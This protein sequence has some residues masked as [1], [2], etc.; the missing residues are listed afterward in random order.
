MK[1]KIQLLIFFAFIM[2]LILVV[3]LIPCTN[4]IVSRGASEDGSTMITYAADSHVLYGELYHW[5]AKSYPPGSMLDVYEWDT[6]KF[7]GQIKQVEQTYNV[8]GN[9]NEHQV[10]I[11]ETT[12]GGRR[13]LRNKKGI[14]DYGS[15]MYIALQRSRTA[16]EAI[17]TMIGLFDEYG[18]YSSGESFSISDPNEVWIMEII[19]KGEGKKGVNWVAVRIPD[20]YI[21]AHANQARIRKFPLNDPKN[22]LYGKDTIS[23]AREMGYFKGKDEDFSFVDAYAPPGYGALRFCEARV[24]SVFNRAAR[25]ENTTFD[26]VKGVEGA[27]PMPLYIKPD[28]KLGVRDVME[29]MRDHFQ[30]TEFDMTKDV[31][32]GPFKLPYRWRG[33]TW[34]VDGVKYCNERAIST[35]QT[36]FSFVTQSRKWLPDP[37]GGIIW[38]GVDDSYST[39]Y[40]PFYCGIDRIPNSFAVGTGSFKEFTWDSAFWVFNFVSNYAYSRYSDM[41]KDI[42]LV[43]GEQETLFVSETRDIDR[44]A[45]NLYKKD[46][47]LARK[48]ITD[49]SVSAGEL[50]VKK[51]MKLGESLLFKYLDGNVKDKDG[52]VTH[53]GYPKEWY[54]HIVKNTGDHFKVKKMR[55][56]IEISFSNELKNGAE[57]LE[58]NDLSKALKHYESALKIKP[59]N[60]F[61]IERAKKVKAIIK[62][63]DD[64]IKKLKDN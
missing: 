48:F 10:A 35:Q 38:F 31:G 44:K 36:G 64:M 55:S 12:Y 30:G 59:G 32:A 57:A 54:K 39:C 51:W 28:R 26:Y 42:R 52:K 2:N 6:G 14:V 37:I 3:E 34:E 13:E 21:S 45:V 63:V 1:K 18:Y 4:I 29:L 56:E 15:A 24:W 61:A 33:L 40:I 27:E 11:G 46:K 23:F 62:N 8:V 41:I 5:P 50:T 53:P 16:R 49:Y 47:A 58:K 25:S 19:G 60:T 7:L 43:Q 9:I 22:C 17:K 20:G